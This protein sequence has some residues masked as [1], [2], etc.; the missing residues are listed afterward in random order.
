MNS[1]PIKIDK[2]KNIFFSPELKEYQSYDGQFYISCTDCKKAF[3]CNPYDL[4]HY[5]KSKVINVKCDNC[6][7]HEFAI[8]RFSHLLFVSCQTCFEKSYFD[9]K[10]PKKC[11]KCGSTNFIVNAVEEIP[12]FPENFGTAFGQKKLDWGVDVNDDLSFLRKELASFKAYPDYHSICFHFIPFFEFQYSRCRYNKNPELKPEIINHAA[13]ML[14]QIFRET[15]D[16]EIGIKSISLIEKVIAEVFEDIDIALYCHNAAMIIYSILSKRQESVFNT[17]LNRDIRNEAIKY[18][19]KSF[20]KYESTSRISLEQKN[21]KC[22]EVEWLMGDIIGADIHT[23]DESSKIKL[24]Q[25][26]S[27]YDKALKRNGIPANTVAYIKESKESKLSKLGSGSIPSESS[28]TTNEFL[29]ESK[30]IVQTLQNYE[31]YAIDKIQKGNHDVGLNYFFKGFSKLRQNLISNSKDTILRNF[32][33]KL[34]NYVLSFSIELS[35]HKRDNLYGLVMLEEFRKYTVADSKSFEE[36]QKENAKKLLQTFL[37]NVL[38]GKPLPEHR[39]IED[40]EYKDIMSPKEELFINIC[41]YIESTDTIILNIDMFR[42]K[43][44]IY[45][46]SPE[47]SNFWDKLL[48]KKIKTELIQIDLK[49][50]ELKLILGTSTNLMFDNAPSLLRNL[51]IERMINIIS[52]KIVPVLQKFNNKNYKIISSAWFIPF[53]SAIRSINPSAIVSY[54]PSLNMAFS[55]TKNLKQTSAKKILIIGYNGLDLPSIEEEI[56][57]IEKTLSDYEIETLT[58]IELSREIVLNKLR[59][60]GYD[61]IHFACHGEYDAINPLSSGLVISSKRKKELL[62]AEDFLTLDKLAVPSLIVL[63]ACSSAVVSPNSSNNVLGLTAAFLRIGVSGIIGSRW[64][65]SDSFALEFMSA[66]YKEIRSGNSPSKSLNNVNS[67]FSSSYTTDESN[68]FVV[69]GG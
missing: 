19:E 58:G 43:F 36:L 15:G 65:V 63:S 8:T 49:E 46:V 51:R 37:Q 50:H 32:G 55:L 60:E 26:V 56:S 14:R 45:V 11:A 13:L 62:S 67:N 47:S 22:A 40:F 48:S 44:I 5:K 52:Y 35:K 42:G 38:S 30:D 69:I 24:T 68:S 2:I 64:P 27:W 12:I 25:S 28:K 61:I 9:S 53:E 4:N 6:H 66:F 18:A 3:W 7:N 54:A 10:K 29:L 39:V 16:V 1:I 41:D 23:I 57:M 21:I 17:I 59:T 20:S 31:L 34:L 33:T